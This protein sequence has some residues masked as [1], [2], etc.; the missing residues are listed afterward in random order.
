LNETTLFVPIVKMD[1]RP[2]GTLLVTG[3]CTG[4]DLDADQ[5]I[6]DP[7]WLAKAV[8]QWFE[9]GANVREMHGL[10]AAGIGK[11]LRQDGNDWYL[12]TLVVDPGSVKKV[13]AG[14]L[15]G[16]SVGIR[17]H[18][19]IKDAA[20]PNGRI[21]DGWLPEISLVDRGAN[22]TCKLALGKAAGVDDVMVDD[23]DA[24][25]DDV[26]E[27]VEDDLLELARRAVAALLYGE[28][29]ELLEG[30]AAMGAIRALLYVLEDLDW[31]AEIDAYEDAVS[32]AAGKDP[33][34]MQITDITK[35]IDAARTAGT[36]EATAQLDELRK[37]LGYELAEQGEMIE[38]EGTSLLKIVKAAAA[39]TATDE[40][41]Q[42][43][44]DLRKGL[45]LEDIADQVTKASEASEERLKALEAD[46][47]KVKELAAPGG[48]ART[49]VAVE[50]ERATQRDEL[51]G[52]AAGM[53]HTAENATNPSTAAAYRDLAARY[54]EQAA[55]IP[56]T[57]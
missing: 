57:S 48:P 38:L 4:P 36:P 45:G 37:A 10:T 46:L 50:A 54:E 29:N 23:P 17:D 51:L 6:A 44:A 47:V 34:P 52:K 5:Q 2:D 39:E 19:V 25:E 8:P 27:A 43:L 15:K 49:R 24:A 13:E 1:K 42:D 28:A 32:K 21:I 30:G 20:A 12:D 33:S 16:Y 26:E 9:S 11:S 14:V 18:R 41:K 3:K 53:R 31:F 40:Q 22:P 35:A 7:A 56:S 55:A